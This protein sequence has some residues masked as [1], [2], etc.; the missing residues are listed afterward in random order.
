MKVQLFVDV[1]PNEPEFAMGF[2]H[3]AYAVV[4]GQ[5]RYF[6]EFDTITGESTVRRC[7]DQAQ[8]EAYP[9]QPETS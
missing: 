4:R 9:A 8:T 7:V 2:A 5:E 6:I 3:P 1:H